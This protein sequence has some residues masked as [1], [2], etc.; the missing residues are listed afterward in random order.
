MGYR[1]DL[2]VHTEEGSACGRSPGADM[3][4]FYKSQGYAGIVITD[5]F[6]TG[7]TRPDRSLPWKEWLAEF[8]KG[9]EHAKARGDEIGLSVFYAWEHS[10]HG[11]DFLTFGL[12][13]Y[14]VQGLLFIVFCIIMKKVKIVYFTSF[15]TGLIYGFVLDMWRKF[16]PF[17]NPDVVKP[18]EQPMWQRIVFLVVGMTLTSLAVA[19]F[20]KIY[21]YPQ[22]YD[23]FVKGLYEV[24]KIPLRRLKTGFD[25]CCLGVAMILTFALFGEVRGIGWGTA[26][27]TLLNGTLIAFFDK[28]LDRFFVFEPVFKNFAKRF[29]LK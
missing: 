11:N 6:F 3:A 23:F 27:M 4:D 16:V 22:V 7:N 18:G 24:K 5:H 20:F 13:E 14:I 15:F 17:L 29:E 2:H 28:M 9:Y 25:T 10:F 1:Y 8:K 26:A 21:I 19:L 12:A